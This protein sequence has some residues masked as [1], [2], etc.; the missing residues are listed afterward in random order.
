RAAVAGGL[1]TV[2]SAPGGIDGA[3]LAGRLTPPGGSRSEMEDTA[4][5]IYRGAI[6]HGARLEAV[7]FVA[8]GG[9][10]AWSW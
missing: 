3:A 10:P 7:I 6:F 4:R 1:G 8:A 9:R 2:F 5:G